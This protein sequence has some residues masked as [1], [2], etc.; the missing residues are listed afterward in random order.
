MTLDDELAELRRAIARPAYMPHK[1]MHERLLARVEAMRAEIHA[2]VYTGEYGCHCDLEP[3]M[4]PDG[5]VID[6]GRPQ[7]CVYARRIERKEQCEYWQP[8]KVTR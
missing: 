5:C 4:K 6:E 1:A 3:D 7:D 2:L 8:I